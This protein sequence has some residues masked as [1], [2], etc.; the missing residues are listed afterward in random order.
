MH[1]S[2]GQR[3]RSRNQM[4]RRSFL[5]G[6]SFAA[7]GGGSVSTQAGDFGK[8]DPP[9]L[10]TARSQFIILEPARQLEPAILNDLYGRPINIARP[11]GTVRLIHIWASWCPACREDLL[12]LER[13]Q[14]SAG[15]EVAITTIS[16]DKISRIRVAEF[17]RQLGI[18]HLQVLLD[19][20]GL[21]ASADAGKKVALPLYGLPITYLIARNGTVAGYIS[22]T[23][24]WNRAEAK[25]LLAY[26]S[27]H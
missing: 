10:S 5:G 27:L 20:D 8:A 9:N 19:P 16:T 11:M 2:E 24:D 15:S 17:L 13:F 7:L 21:V 3:S 4:T 14:K 23:V 6:L 26:Y 22:G 18:E 1:K 25:E 12:E